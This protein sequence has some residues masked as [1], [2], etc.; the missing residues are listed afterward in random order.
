MRISA[1]TMSV[2]LELAVVT[3]RRRLP[4][5]SQDRATREPL[6]WLALP[7]VVLEVVERFTAGSALV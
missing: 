7:V 5:G 2:L 6:V 1:F 3:I 4:H